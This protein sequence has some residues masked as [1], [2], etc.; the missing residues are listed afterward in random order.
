MWYSVCWY[1]V[2]GGVEDEW[3]NQIQEKDSTGNGAGLKPGVL[4]IDWCKYAKLLHHSVIVL[5]VGSYRI[6]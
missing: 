6:V 5:Y 4:Q 3:R 2:L 1:Y